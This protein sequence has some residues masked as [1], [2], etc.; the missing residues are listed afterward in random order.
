MQSWLPLLTI[1]PDY[2]A[3]HETWM[4]VIKNEV[5]GYYSFDE[6]AE[7]LW[8]D[9]LWVLPAFMG[10]GIGKSLFGHA[11]E[12]ARGS[13]ASILMVE[14]DPNAKSFYEKMGAQKV[15]EHRGEVDGQPRILPVLEISL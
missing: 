12:R 1:T 9:N 5:V 3:S 2:I 4:A 7:G 10:H 11:L 14:A 15:G 6:N 8:L 13:G